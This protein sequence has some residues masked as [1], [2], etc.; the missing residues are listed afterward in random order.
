MVKIKATD[1]LELLEIPVAELIQFANKTPY[2]YRNLGC[3]IMEKL[4]MERVRAEI[5]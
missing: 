3:L 2:I 1:T 5:I 4:K